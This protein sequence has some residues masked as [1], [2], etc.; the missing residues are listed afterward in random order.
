MLNTFRDFREA[1]KNRTPE[2]WTAWVVLMKIVYDEVALLGLQDADRDDLVQIVCMKLMR[3][4]QDEES[5]DAPIR[6]WIKTAAFNENIDQNIRK[7]IPRIEVAQMKFLYGYDPV[8]KE[9][10]QSIAHDL[11]RGR[12]R[13][14]YGRMTL[15]TEK[16]DETEEDVLKEL[17][18]RDE[19]NRLYG[20]LKTLQPTEKA[21]V[22][23]KGLL[24]LSYNE[25]AR[26]MKEYFG[27]GARPETWRKRY[28]RLR[29]Q[30]AFL[31]APLCFQVHGQYQR[32]VVRSHQLRSQANQQV[33]QT[34]HLRHGVCTDRTV[35]TMCDS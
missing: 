30:L 11:R 16:C 28:E 10:R 8:E 22:V 32:I 14:R 25:V 33:W 26:I 3:E 6:P 21:L 20:V 1:T 4:L 9:L 15:P 13:D 18:R 7:T 35:S 2:E 5:S 34:K 19:A 24:E 31:L 29:K 27:Q 12:G 23:S 17:V